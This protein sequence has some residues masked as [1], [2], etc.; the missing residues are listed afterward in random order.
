M[1]DVFGMLCVLG[2][3]LAFGILRV[4]LVYVVRIPVVGYRFCYC[5]MFLGGR[6][7]AWVRAAGAVPAG[8]GGFWWIPVGSD[9]QRRG[10]S[11]RAGGSASKRS[12]DGA[13][14]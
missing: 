9:G 10:C 3:E 12:D 8:S 13:H 5:V 11:G 1:C 2:L 4:F 6:A 7:G 14:W